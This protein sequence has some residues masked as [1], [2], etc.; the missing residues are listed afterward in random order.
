MSGGA[1][2]SFSAAK[3]RRA[4]EISEVAASGQAFHDVDG[5]HYRGLVPDLNF[6]HS[7]GGTEI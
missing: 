5:K 3:S 6:V 7:A 2:S 4:S 1:R